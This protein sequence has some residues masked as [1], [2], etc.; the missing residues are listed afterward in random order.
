MTAGT[1]HPTWGQGVR[2][3]RSLHGI[4]QEQLAERAGT[5]QTAISDL[6]NGKRRRISDS[7]RIRI[8]RELHADPYDLFP[9]LDD[10]GAA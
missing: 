2:A 3:L 7:L 5:T 1:D 9:Y 6:E 4:T 10:N 8:A